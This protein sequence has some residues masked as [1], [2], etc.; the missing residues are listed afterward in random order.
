[1]TRQSKLKSLGASVLMMGAAAF[2]NAETIKIALAGENGEELASRL[3]FHER[4]SGRLQVSLEGRKQFDKR[5]TLPN[6]VEIVD[7]DTA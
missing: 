4:A 7:L 1:M 6:C 3:M 5:E 2:A